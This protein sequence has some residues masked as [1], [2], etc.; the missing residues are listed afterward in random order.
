MTAIINIICTALISFTVNMTGNFMSLA[1]VDAGNF[2]RIR[3]LSIFHLA[4]VFF[5]FVF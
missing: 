1:A 5:F 4:T 2:V 3:I